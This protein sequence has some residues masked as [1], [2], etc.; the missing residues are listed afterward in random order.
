V[1]E[2]ESLE[3][4][5]VT[6]GEEIRSGYVYPAWPSPPRKL[7]G[8]K[9]TGGPETEDLIEFTRCQGQEREQS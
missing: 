6:L 8:R 7:N 2:E 4:P 5:E 3:R 1:E 9:G